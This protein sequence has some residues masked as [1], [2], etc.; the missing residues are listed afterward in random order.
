MMSKA[1][2]DVWEKHRYGIVYQFSWNCD[3]PARRGIKAQK[4]RE[5]KKGCMSW[6]GLPSF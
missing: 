6:K 3:I 4:T 2:G 5:A 1:K